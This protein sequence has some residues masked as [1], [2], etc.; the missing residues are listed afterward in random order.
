MRL[1][2]TQAH[3]GEGIFPTFK[4]GVEVKLISACERYL[5]WYQAEMEGYTTYIPIHFVE[6]GKLVC[7]Y[8]P[9]E[10]VAHAN[11]SVELLELH[12]EWALVRRE[13]EVGWLPCKILK[14]I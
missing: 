11:E 7:D 10:L 9:T 1:I 13:H 3:Q 8:N 2:T 14:S 12:Y 4:Q 6:H 5:H